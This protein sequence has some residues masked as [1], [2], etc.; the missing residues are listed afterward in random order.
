MDKP[1]LA[2]VLDERLPL[3]QHLFLAPATSQSMHAFPMR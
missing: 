1:F 2:A 3:V